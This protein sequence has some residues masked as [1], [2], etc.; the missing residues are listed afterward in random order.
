MLILYGM[1][2]KAGKHSLLSH[3]EICPGAPRDYRAPCPLQL[4][5]PCSS[6][7]PTESRQ[8]DDSLVQ[9]LIFSPKPPCSLFPYL[10]AER[11]MAHLPGPGG[12]RT[13]AGERQEVGA[14]LPEPVFGGELPRRATRPG[15]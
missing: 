9:A 7:L 15:T 3:I 11:R 5:G 1:L 12:G 10:L 14:R 2:P 4:G 8:S 13:T 6:T